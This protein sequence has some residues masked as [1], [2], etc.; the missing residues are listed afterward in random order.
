M[1]SRNHHL[2]QLL[3]TTH[4][5]FYLVIFIAIELLI[6][7]GL[8]YRYQEQHNNIIDEYT[9]NL[10]TTHQIVMD[11]LD[12]VSQTVFNEIIYQSEII[13][14]IKQANQQPPKQRQDLQQKLLQKLL[15]SHEHFKKQNLKL[16][17]FYLNDNSHFLNFD[18]YT[19]AQLLA[20]TPQQLTATLNLAQ[21]TARGFKNDSYGH[22]FRHI[23]PIMV[24]NNCIGNIEIGLSIDAIVSEMLRVRREH[25]DFIFNK[26]SVPAPTLEKESTQFEASQLSERFLQHISDLSH[27]QKKYSPPA[28]RLLSTINQALRHR[29]AQKLNSNLPFVEFATLEMQTFSATFLPVNSVDDKT[30]GYLVAYVRDTKLRE[31]SQDFSIHLFILSLVNGAFIFFIFQANHNRHLVEYQKENLITSNTI[32]ERWVDE[33]VSELIETNISLHQEIL[34]RKKIEEQLK[35]YQDHLEELVEERTQQLSNVNNEL[36]QFNRERVK[37][38]I[39][40]R[41]TE[42]ALRESEEMFRRVSQSLVDALVVINGLGKVIFWSQSAERIFGYT[43]AEAVGNNLH[44]MI[45]PQGT[46]PAIAQAL[47]KFAESGEGSVFNRLLEFHASRRNGERFPIE[48]S[49]VALKLKEEWTAVSTIRDITDRRQKEQE[50]QAALGAM[51]QAN[52]IIAEKNREI[53]DNYTQLQQTLQHLQTAQRELIQSE[54][55]AALGQLIAG[56]AH[57]INTP[58]GA[59]RSS[60]ANIEEFVRR[61]LLKIPHFFQTLNVER[62]TDFFALLKLAIGQ[63]EILTSKEKRQLRK[64]M[65]LSLIEAQLT[66]PELLADRLIDIGIY[67]DI[68]PWL[69]LLQSVDN[70]RVLEMVYQIVSLQKSTST[71][72]TASDRAAKVV[73]ALKSFSRFDHSGQKVLSQISDSIETVLTLYHNKLKFGI[74]LNRNYEVVPRT[75]CFPDELNQVWTNL[76]HNAL[77]AMNNQGVL[78]IQVKMQN[79]YIV[80]S[81][82]DTGHGIPEAIKQRIFEPF[83]TTKPIGEGSGLGLDIVKKIIE[84]HGGKIELHSQLGQGTTFEVFLPIILEVEPTTLS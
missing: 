84:K 77:Q 19:D 57:E 69:A 28:L 50:L 65:A 70:Q 9:N 62:Q 10:Q 25:Y 66:E 53:S 75:Y 14:L 42:V 78:T 46:T 22:Y 40:L 11:T 76:I 56:V 33:R 31:L 3:K 13:E 59:I 21:E 29:V 54:K 23:Y 38:I 2:T 34:D 58:L 60:V 63:K 74:E 64:K 35:L 81:I 79:S 82:S 44:N 68:S 67:D 37:D 48:V 39:K 16:I 26:T 12:V 71:I 61:D 6:F 5:K 73:F 36:I 27:G 72:T 17:N 32:L 30:I 4:W 7:F 52:R 20:A 49:I 55:M 18:L 8:R 43:E 47:Q 41:Q 80:V 15:P 45:L 51:E 1:I 24:Q 83:F